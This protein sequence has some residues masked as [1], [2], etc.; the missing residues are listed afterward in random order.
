M[1]SGGTFVGYEC[2]LYCRV[3]LLP[4]TS[5]RK[6]PGSTR[7]SSFVSPTSIQARTNGFSVAVCHGGLD[8]AITW[9]MVAPAGSR[10]SPA[11][12]AAR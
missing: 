6:G 7:A 11:S 1:I 4:V 5:A 9:S 2:A 10:I 12:K 8:R 3:R